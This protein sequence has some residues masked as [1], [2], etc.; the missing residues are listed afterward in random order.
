M[1]RITWPRMAGFIRSEVERILD[2]EIIHAPDF[3]S[4]TMHEEPVPYF[5]GE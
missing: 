1:H 3:D 4:M 5:A 2:A